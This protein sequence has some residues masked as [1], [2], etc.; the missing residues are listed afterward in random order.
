[1]FL[2]CVYP[3]N[4]T[5]KLE[6]IVCR[7]ILN[8]FF[9]RNIFIIFAQDN[10]RIFTSGLFNRFFIRHALVGVLDLD[11]ARFSCKQNR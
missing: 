5:Y 4:Y 1:M 11:S 7:F 3:E 8:L 6:R 9:V 10:F 2:G